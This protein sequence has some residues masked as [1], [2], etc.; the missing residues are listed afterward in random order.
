MTTIDTSLSIVVVVLVFVAALLVAAETAIGRVSRTRVE[1]L[2]REGNK[3]AETL[4]KVL[5]DRARHVNV[6]LFLST[7]ATVSATSIL[8]VLAVDTFDSGMA[9][10]WSVV[11]MVVLSYV[12]VG[13]APRTIGR[14]KSETVALRSARMSQ[15]LT[16]VLGPLASLLILV[17]N[18][19]TP[20]RGYS[21]G[22][23][24]TQAEL[25]E[26]V[27]LAGADMV[28]EDDERQMIHSVFELGD[29]M[30]REVMV[31]RTDMV[32]IEQDKTLRQAMSLELRS[33]YSRI[34][35]IGENADDVVGVVYLKDIISKIFADREAETKVTVDA[36][37]RPAFFVPDSKRVD[38]LLK[39]M[40]TARTHMAIV[41]DEYGGTAG[42]VTIEDVLEEIVGEIA[43]E[44]DTGTPEVVHL[45]DGSIRVS[46][47][48]H[49]DDFA[50][51]IDVDLDSDE[52]GVETLLGYMAKRLGRVP[53]PG[54]VVQVENWQL[55]AERAVG[56]RNK[57][58][59]IVL[60]RLERPETE[61]DD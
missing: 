51:L 46:S 13:V 5:D 47:R 55:L 40:Q 37:M 56:R 39:D 48:I 58:G 60:T 16:T 50:D 31:P 4:L 7:L 29:T 10:F 12:V 24:A 17:G 19:V 25:R 6:L 2:R 27:D 28:I 53:I 61:D 52:E 8:A 36:L 41:V 21:E 18:A 26:M 9:I 22:P 44:H 42:L 38:D 59:D 43:D 32:F 33:G 45:E 14:Q 57:V 30:A 35:V 11:I 34:P 54:A 3:K 15:V 49:I 1:E 23:F 20:G